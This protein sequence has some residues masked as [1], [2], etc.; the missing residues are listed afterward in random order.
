[1]IL[2]TVEHAL[3]TFESTTVENEALEVIYRYKLLF[4]FCESNPSGLPKVILLDFF[5]IQCQKYLPKWSRVTPI[6]FATYS[7]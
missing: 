7:T 2:N 5:S 1:M 4:D 3:Q 6:I